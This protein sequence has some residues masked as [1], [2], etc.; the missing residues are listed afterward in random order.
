MSHSVPGHSTVFKGLTKQVSLSAALCSAEIFQRIRTIHRE[1]WER[2][3]VLGHWAHTHCPSVF[4]FTL[5][6]DALECRICHL[7][8]RI[9]QTDRDP[10]RLC[11]MIMKDTIRKAKEVRWSTGLIRHYQQIQV[12]GLKGKMFCLLGFRMGS[13]LIHCRSL[14]CVLWNKC[15]P[16][17]ELWLVGGALLHPLY[18]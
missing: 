17:R 18:E 14:S 9:S 5:G 8:C 7:F 12:T 4:W 6:N 13:S 10:K 1:R 16:W 2:H 3:V 11:V 15:Q